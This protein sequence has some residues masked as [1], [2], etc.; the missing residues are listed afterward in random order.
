MAFRSHS[1]NFRGLLAGLLLIGSLLAV[2]LTHAGDAVIASSTA[3][4]PDRP[5][6]LDERP[7]GPDCIKGPLRYLFFQGCAGAD[8][9]PACVGHDACYDRIGSDKDECDRCFFE[10]MLAECEKSKHPRNAKFRAKMAY[11]A[12]K[13]F[14]KGAWEDAQILS[15]QQ[16]GRFLTR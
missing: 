3:S 13:V 1:L 8:F 11:L 4:N 7:C 10:A 15:L 14:G 12:V 9:R 5:A 6:I 2:P 16:V